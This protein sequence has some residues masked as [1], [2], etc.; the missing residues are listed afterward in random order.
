M[1]FLRIFALAASGLSGIA[2]AQLTS[3]FFEASQIHQI[4]LVVAPADW[5]SLSSNTVDGEN[6]YYQATI[7]IDGAAPLT[8][9]IRQHGTGSRSSAKPSVLI[10]FSE[11]VKN[12][13]FLGLDKI[14]AKNNIEDA[15]NLHEF[16]SFKLLR[17]MGLPAP[18]VVPA[19]LYVNGTYLGFYMIDEHIDSVYLDRNFGEDGGYLYNWEPAGTYN[20]ADL[21][22]DPSAY[23]QFLE[24]KSNQATPDL[25]NF[26]QLVQA[27]N[28]AS[29]ADF[30]AD[31]SQYLNPE[32][33]LNLAAVENVLSERDGIVD[34]VYGMNNFYI[35]Q[36]EGGALYQFLGWDMVLAFGPANLPPE[37]TPQ[38]NVL[39][40]RLL[41]IPQ[42]RDYYYTALVRAASSFGG[43]G[44]WA[45]T[46]LSQEYSVIAA[47]A[48]NDPNKQCIA[49]T[50]YVPCGAAQFEAEVSNMH[51][52]IASRSNFVLNAA[53][54]SGYSPFVGPSISGAALAGAPDVPTLSAGAPVTVQGSGLG[55]DYAAPDTPLLRANGNTNFVTVDGIRAPLFSTSDGS[56]VL[57]IPWDLPSQ[58]TFSIVS[59]VGGQQSDPFFVSLQTTSPAILQVAHADGTPVNSASPAAA[60]EVVQIYAVGLGPVSVTPADGTPPYVPTSTNT[61]PVV[62]VGENQAQV[63]FSGL[64][65][66]MVGIYQVNVTMPSADSGSVTL[67]MNI[68]SQTSAYALYAQ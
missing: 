33:Y 8:V 4:N 55:G 40:Q 26:E 63:Q 20:F 52:F 61:I 30:I 34:G 44:G 64:S 59:A 36:F 5:A 37:Q 57:Q 3:P 31:V 50:G 27:I 18:R 53:E 16:I 13:S 43:P 62:F 68:G 66:Q 49:V 22:T 9:G 45:D 67:T 23:A 17:R 25:Q 2:F 47:A 46:E 56:A 42:Y 60:G 29:D 19:Q 65:P 12:Q 48:E 15:S 58:G 7:G 10:D 11:Y 35:Y 24:L 41:A 21:G 38:P 51:A 14:L 28:Y 6:T 54:Q 39:V 1:P 32:L